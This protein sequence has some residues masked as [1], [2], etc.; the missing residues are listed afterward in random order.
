MKYLMTALLCFVFIAAS[1][2]GDDKDCEP[3]DPAVT[4][5]AQSD[6]ATDLTDTVSDTAESDEV[7]EDAVATEDAP[8]SDTDEATTPEDVDDSAPE[9][10]AELP[11]DDS[12]PADS[13]P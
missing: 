12:L 6:D 8:E 10:A 1:A 3:G 4:A 5:D 11:E 9:D 7:S 13:T 2:C